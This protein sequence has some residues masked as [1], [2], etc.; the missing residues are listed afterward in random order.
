MTVPRDDPQTGCV[1]EMTGGQNP[2][3]RVVPSRSAGKWNPRPST[4]KH[5]LRA[6]V[7]DRM[8]SLRRSLVVPIVVVA[9]VSSLL[10]ANA[11]ADVRRIVVPEGTVRELAGVYDA[12]ALEVLGTLRATGPDALLQADLVHVGPKGL[13]E[14][15]PGAAGTGGMQ[16][17]G[18]PGSPGGSLTLIAHQ[19]VVDEGGLILGGPGGAGG[20]AQDASHALGGVGGV[21]GSVLVQSAQVEVRGHILPGGGG[22]GG[23]AS[24]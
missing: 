4:R 11:Q 5:P 21:G 1:H 15:R 17:A 9:C 20:N 6:R 3:C 8:P 23:A 19:V 14:G 16:P 22:H 10:P 24:V 18:A 12:S 13:I 2:R 7:S